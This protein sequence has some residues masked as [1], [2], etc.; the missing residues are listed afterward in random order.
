MKKILFVLLLSLPFFVITAYQNPPMTYDGIYQEV[1]PPAIDPQVQMQMQKAPLKIATPQVKREKEPEAYEVVVTARRI[2]EMLRLIPRS[3]EI[4]TQ[5]EIENFGISKL[6]DILDGSAGTYINKNGGNEGAASLS[7]RGA[8]S[9]QVL[10]LIDSVPVNDIM[11]GGFDLNNISTDSI[12]RIEVVK[13]GLSSIYGADAMA[14]VVNIITNPNDKKII[15]GSAAYGTYGWQKQTIG[16]N[17]KIFNLG[18]SANGLEE[19]SGGYITNSDYLK[20]I[21]DGKLTFGTEASETMLTGYYLKKSAGLPGTISWASPNSK[22]YNEDY[23][24]GGEEKLDLSAIK[25]KAAGYEK[26]NDLIYIDDFGTVSRHIKKETQ[27]SVM[28]IYNENGF[29]SAVGGYELTNKTLDSTAVGDRVMR[30]NAILLNA[31]IIP[32]KDLNINAGAR[33]DMNSIYKNTLS[34]NAGV[35]YALGGDTDVHI[36]LEDSYT[37]PTFGD[38]Y[39]PEE[40]YGYMK[41]MGNENLKPEKSK[42]Y[43]VGINKKGDKFEETLTW[44]RRDVSDLIEWVFD[45]DTYILQPVNVS[46]SVIMGL[47]AK[48]AYTPF[49]FLAAKLSYTYMSA[50]DAATGKKLL[51][52]PE[53]KINGMLSVTLP[54]SL[55][56]NA[57]GEYVDNRVYSSTGEDLKAYY[58]LNINVTHTLNDN[59]KI[60]CNID[61]VLDNTKYQVLHD[62][63]MPGRTI[64]A[65]LEAGF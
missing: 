35:K 2:P 14:G 55:K 13:G 30:N 47:E 27:G 33:Y 52:R 25:L 29:L 42:S 48:I 59:M 62:Y 4:I 64:K 41:I 53:G 49:D 56:I 60:V 45:T 5:K 12:D 17:F 46:K 50:L 16:T 58:L 7:I 3:V 31:T 19:K 39:W 37:S 26:S 24:I 40:D 28:A 20:R 57:T 21:V 32:I 8:S 38:L 44:F 23:I 9:G 36:T 15:K 10:V 22:Q 1:P 6:G 65:G 63:R 61:N 43:E 11:T 54:M 51:N 34:L 18:V